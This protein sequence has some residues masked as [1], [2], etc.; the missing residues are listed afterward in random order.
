MN[1][2]GVW[3]IYRTEMMLCITVRAVRSTSAR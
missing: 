1:W 3:A 2:R